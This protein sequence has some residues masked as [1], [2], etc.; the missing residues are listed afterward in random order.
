MSLKY[1]LACGSVPL[2]VSPEYLDFFSRGL[3]PQ[4]NYLPVQPSDLCLSIKLAVEWGYG[5]PDMVPLLSYLALKFSLFS[6][7]TRIIVRC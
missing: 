3:T 6:S 5:H 2:I 7:L 4:K 1:I